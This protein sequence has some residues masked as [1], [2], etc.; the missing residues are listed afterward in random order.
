MWTSHRSWLW[1]G[2]RALVV[3]LALAA[4][5]LLPVTPLGGQTGNGT[6]TVVRIEED[7]SLT[8]NQP[9]ENL[10]CPQLSTQM[11]RCPTASRFCNFHL[12]ACDLPSF[13][14]GGLQLQVWNGSTNIAVLTS[15]N[16]NIMNTPNELV[17]WTQ[18][19]RYDAPSNQLAFGVTNG[20][21]TTWGDFSGLEVFVP[22]GGTDLSNYD[23]TYSVQNSGI[24]FGANRVDSLVLVGYR[25]YYSDGSVVTD[26]TPRVVYSPN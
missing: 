9:D 7:W 23:V 19:L 6:P 18:Y 17:T 11:A 15:P 25:V 12:N 13:A 3:A 4:V 5:S 14:L 16:A 26:S 21:S 1:C 20:S 8:V 2:L 10:A 22:G 24:T